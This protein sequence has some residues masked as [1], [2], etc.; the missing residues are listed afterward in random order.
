MCPSVSRRPIWRGSGQIP[1]HRCDTQ[2]GR[3]CVATWERMKNGLS[4]DEV[5]TPAYATRQQHT[6]VKHG[7]MFSVTRGGANKPQVLFKQEVCA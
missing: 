5:S 7:H 1:P 6:T 2:Q 3:L 4:F